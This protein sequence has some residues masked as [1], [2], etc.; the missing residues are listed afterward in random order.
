ML[1]GGVIASNIY[2][3]DDAPQYKRGNS[4]L[5]SIVGLNITLYAL[6]KVYY[7]S[8]N[9]YRESVWNR[10]P[11]DERV[12]Y[13]ATTHDAGNKRLDFRFAS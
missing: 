8:R 2:R 7:V 10:M 11:E 5:L 4:V 6:T 1:R 13:L 12:Q 9:R 3:E